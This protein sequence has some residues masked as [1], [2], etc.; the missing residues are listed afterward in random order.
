M[1]SDLP[2]N[3]EG[4]KTKKSSEHVFQT[5]TNDH[6]EKGVK[7]MKALDVI[8]LLEARV[9]EKDSWHSELYGPLH[10]KPN[11]GIKKVLYC[12]TATDAVQD[13]FYEHSY[14]LLISHHPFPAHGIPQFICHT[15][16]DCCE[17]GLNDMWAKQ[18][19][20]QGAKHFVDN[21]G[22][23]GEIEPKTFEQLCK[24]I[25]AFAGPIRGQKFNTTKI[26]RSVCI[27]TGLGGLVIRE[28]AS[29]KA[30]CYILGEA[31]GPAESMGGRRS[32]SQDPQAGPFHHLDQVRHGEVMFQ[33][34]EQKVAR[35]GDSL[36]VNR[37]ANQLCRMIRR[38]LQD[39]VAETGDALISW[40]RVQ[41]F[42]QLDRG[43]D[44]P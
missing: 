22:W 34:V 10:V 38:Q 16:L 39:Q 19:K 44:R 5:F 41:P 20:L 24:E 42:A 17:G 26:I 35:A 29:S 18:L 27:C 4:I 43:Q 14:D 3:Q 13:Y 21:L 31:C 11:A 30:D 33:H 37:A 36:K 23:F 8:K 9:P 2:L 40:W 6:V 12:V 15:A 7:I 32:P 28:A 25:E 1:I